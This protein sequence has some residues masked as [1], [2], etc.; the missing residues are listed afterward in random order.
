VSLAV[1]TRTTCAWEP[2][3][4]STKRS[5]AAGGNRPP[6]QMKRVPRIETVSSEPTGSGDAPP[7]SGLIG[8]SSAR[9]AKVVDMP[10]RNVLPCRTGVGLF[11]PSGASE[12]GKEGGAGGHASIC[13]GKM[14]RDDRFRHILP[15]HFRLVK[16]RIL[17]TSPQ[18]QSWEE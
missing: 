18:E 14:A 4:K 12:K 9:A 7:E 5:I 8:Q 11:I 1:V 13:D 3:A 6:P 2:P 15:M 10:V 16:C 17:T